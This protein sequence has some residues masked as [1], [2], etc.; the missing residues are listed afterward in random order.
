MKNEDFRIIADKVKVALAPQDIEEQK[1]RE[2]DDNE[3]VALF[4]GKAVAYTIVYYYDKK[5]IVIRT[6]S[7]TDDGPDNEWKT[8]ATW[9]FDPDTDGKKEA[10]SIA[11]DFSEAVSNTSA[12]RRIKT[13]KA[14]KKKNEDEGNADPEFLAKRFVA[15]FPDLKGEIKEEDDN[16][17]PFRG[18]TFTREKIL[19][20]LNS[21]IET[22]NKSEI[23]KLT[24]L[25]NTQYANGN[26]DTRAIITIVILNSIPESKW[27]TVYELLDEDLQKAWKGARKYKDKKVKPEKKKKKKKSMMQ[28]LSETDR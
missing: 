24:R 28:R 14:K 19:T 10:A 15:L 5:H 22:A 26:S 11:N 13:T 12:I 3:K 7:M 25:L 16:Y 1:V 18:V 27:D 20:K 21:Y 17:Y 9:M 23:E 8:L 4:T 6:C 2:S